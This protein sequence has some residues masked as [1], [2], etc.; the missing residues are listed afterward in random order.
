MDFHDADTLIRQYV[1]R[2][3]KAGAHG[4]EYFDCYGLVWHL[5]KTHGDTLLPRFDDENYQ[6]ARIKAT[7]EGQALSDDWEQVD[8][9]QDFDSVLLQ[10]NPTEAYHVGAYLCLGDASQG[11]VLHAMPGH[12]VVCSDFQGLSRMGFKRIEFYRYVCR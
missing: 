2:P 6:L 5:A 1:G 9:P 8:E 12:G 4:P 10:R 7:I 3:F 11:R